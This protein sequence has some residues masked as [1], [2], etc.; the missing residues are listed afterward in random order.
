MAV[1]L[2]DDELT[3]FIRTII[4]PTLTRPFGEVSLAGIMQTTQ[5]QMAQA[6]GIEAHQRSVRAIL[7]RLRAQRRVRR[8]ADEAGRP[9]VGVRPGDLPARQAAHVLRALRQM[10][11]SDVPILDDREFFAQ[12]LAGVDLS[13]LAE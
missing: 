9:D 11:L 3:V 13:D 5:L 12:L 8:M 4:E 1:G 6:Q 2:T 10:F 7:R